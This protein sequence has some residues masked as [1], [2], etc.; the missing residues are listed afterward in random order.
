MR[1]RAL[2]LSLLAALFAAPAPAE[3]RR[4][5]GAPQL[6]QQIQRLR[7][8]GSVLMIAAH[9]DD[10]NTALL[11][12]CAQR[13]MLRTGYLSLTRGEGG[14]N[15]IG[16]EQGDLLGVIRTQELLAARRIDGAEQFFSRAIDF[17][18]SKTADETLAKWGR[19]QVLSDAVWVIRRF[20]P[21]VIILR[22]SGTPRDGHG[23]HQS[24]SLIGQEAFKLAA[25]PSAFPEQLKYVQPWQ[26]RRILWNGFSFTRQ[27]EQDLEKTPQRLMVDTGEYSPVLGMSYG[28]LAGLSRSQHRSQG[29]GSAERKGALPNYLFH[30]GGEKAENDLFDGVDTSW[31]RIPGGAPVDRELAAA[32]AAY[33]IDAPEK[34]LPALLRARTLIAAL[35]HPDARRKLAEIDETIALAAGL[36]LDLSAARPAVTPGS[37]VNLS[38]TAVLRGRTS[39]RLD[40]VTLDGIAGAPTFPAAALL[41]NQPHTAQAALKIPIDQP[42]T[43]PI[44]LRHPRQGNLYNIPDPNDIGLAEAPPVLAARFR[45][46]VDGAPIEITRPVENRYVDRVRGE[47]TRPFIVVPAVSLRLSDTPLLFSTASPRQVSVEIKANSAA[48]TGSVALAAPTGWTVTPAEAPFTLAET[49]QVATAAFTVTPPAASS[50]GDLRI[51]ARTNGQTWTTAATQLTYEHIPPQTILRQAAARVLRNDIHV[52]AKRAGYVMG[53]GD[54]VPEA[55]RELGLEVTLLDST[56]LA[57]GDL[58][59]FDVIVTGVRAWNVRDDLRAAHARLRDYIERGGTLVVQYNTLDGFPG[60]P[61]SDTLKNIGPFPITISRDRTTVE[62]APVTFLLPDHR[63]LQTPNHITSADFDNWVQERALYFPSQWAPEYQAILECHDPNEPARNGGLLYTRLGKGAYVFTS[64]VFFRQLPAGN[65]GAYRLFANLV[66]AA[67]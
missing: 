37:S 23:H 12:W 19:Q 52:S 47:L 66:S 22:F 36:W 25:D 28:E 61:A 65:P 32:A 62:E 10:E 41:P 50:Q 40:S 5:S 63:L 55:L 6:Y 35:N 45:L 21:D 42:L 39:A 7:T 16:D 30:Y 3:F 2:V 1:L 54:L 31:N 56:A 20:R 58:S 18:F 14:Q 49:G 46:T 34:T 59:R 44:Q 17:G 13:R 48:A 15:L 67:K 8:V 26:A 24:S 64:Y 60:A 9:P 57:Q 38:L 11:A 4:A 53:A 51:T 27:Q 33:S 43:Q 29:F